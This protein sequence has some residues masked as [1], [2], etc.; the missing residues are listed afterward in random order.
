MPNCE[1]CHDDL[2]EESSRL[3]PPLLSTLGDQRREYIEQ[4]WG[5]VP[6]ALCAKDFL[7]MIGQVNTEVAGVG[8]A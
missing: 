1:W 6:G 4:T 2:S 8:I 3:I 7:V 5:S